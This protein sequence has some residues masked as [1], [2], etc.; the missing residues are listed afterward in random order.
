MTF[1]VVLLSVVSAV[2]QPVAVRHSDSLPAAVIEEWRVSAHPVNIIVKTN[3][4]ALLWPSEKKRNGREVLYKAY[5]SKHSNFPV[6]ETIAGPA[7]KFCFFNPH[8]KLDVGK[9]YWK[10]EII[11][12]AE[13]T[14]KGPYAFTVDNQAGV[15]ETPG[16]ESFLANI[17]QGHPRVMNHGNDLDRIRK[18]APGHPIY[19][20]VMKA[21]H[22]ALKAE[23][24]RGPIVGKTPADERALNR[25]GGR[26]I[27][28]YNDLL[29]AY[30]LSG[31]EAMLQQ[32]TERL[33]VLLSW[34]TDDLLGSQVMIA[35]ARG[36][37]ALYN[38]LPAGMKQSLLKTIEHQLDEG[39]KKWPGLI[40]AR[41]VENHFWQMELSGNFTAALATVR[42]LP[43]SSQMLEYTYEL[44]IARFPNL[45][46]QEGGWA[47][48]IGYFGVNKLAIVDMA[49]LMKKVGG[50]DVFKMNW[51]KNLADYFYYFAPVDGR[52][53]GF[54]DMHD[55][56]GYGNVGHAMMLAVGEENRD[57]KALYRLSMLLGSEKKAK[58]SEQDYEKKLEKVEP[59]YQIVNN[60]RFRPEK[61]PAPADMPS[62]K[63][64]GGVGLA[65]FHTNVLN[66]RNNMAL[67]FRSSPFGAKGH[68]H[69]N[70]NC[71]NISRKGEPV[72]YSTG[73]YTTFA[74]PHSLTSYRHT[75]AHNG[76]L[77]NGLGQAFGH[78]GYGWIKR[79]IN[80]E[81]A[82][83]VCGDATMAYRPVVDGQFLG[84]LSENNIQPTP[85]SGFGDAKLKLFERHIVFLRP[86]TI[87]IYDVLEA[88]D[89]SQW[90]FLLHTM[91]KPELNGRQLLTLQSGPNYAE[92]Y[93]AASGS[94]NA[95]V[96]DQFFIPPVDIKKK[97]TALPDQYHVSYTT[98]AKS[99][100]MRFLAVLQLNDAGSAVEKVVKVNEGVYKVGN[101]VIGA[102]MNP[103]KQTSLSVKG[104]DV[105]MRIGKDKTVLEEQVNGRTKTSTCGNI[106]LLSAAE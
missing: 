65:A 25:T 82:G 37:D 69:A 22:K 80:G 1:S 31:N 102:E 66:S 47:E 44:F 52:I 27:G 84:L 41:H 13:V 5:L 15:F 2:F 93:V 42:D 78:E 67:Y 55:R 29:E 92:A 81:K 85:A 90:T 59:W 105:N 61:I 35:L 24:Y 8:R 91:D 4:T 95:K 79:F 7:K 70:Q 63:M 16:F 68:M 38:Q 43:V 101:V 10:Y 62:A 98:S 40:E 39:L 12:G 58:E 36:Y 21:G 32:L 17:K 64:F 57:P 73:Y 14:T 3:P 11:D 77:V 26:E 86:G 94:L 72:F 56:V 23:I 18:E 89:P 74:D 34:P 19:E 106:S 48:G 60:V 104:G 49:L 97:Y 46:T 28:V 45:A 100:G 87:I 30:I 83:Y 53:S 88:E 33:K 9:W 76:I 50:V 96:T 51:Y 103:A 54:G 20:G 71:F 99:K 6:K 75:R